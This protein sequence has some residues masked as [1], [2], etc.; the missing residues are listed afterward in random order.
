MK[1]ITTTS[2]TQKRYLKNKCFI[3]YAPKTFGDKFKSSHRRCSVKKG[4]LRNFVKFTGKHLC[5]SLFL[6]KLQALACNFK[7]QTLAQAFPC[8][9]CK[10]SKNTFLQNTSVRLLPTVT[11]NFQALPFKFGSG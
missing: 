5:Q 9:C 3:R 2:T 6:I 10:T 7:R 11:C 8:K 1:P 4:V